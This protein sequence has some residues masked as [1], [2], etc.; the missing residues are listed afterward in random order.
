M[1]T[2]VEAGKLEEATMQAKEV[3][4]LLHAFALSGQCVL[5]PFGE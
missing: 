4:S 5:N 1:V 3:R 2:Y